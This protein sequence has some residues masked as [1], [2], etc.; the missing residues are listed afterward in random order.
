MPRR[1]LKIAGFTGRMPRLV[2]CGGRESAYDGFKAC[3]ARAS[4]REFAALLIDSE[5]P[6]R[7]VN[8]TWRHLR[9]GDH[10]VQP[11]GAQDNQVLLMTT[12]METWVMADPDAVERH[13]GQGLQKRELLP[14]AGLEKRSRAEVQDTLE[15]VT[16]RCSVPYQKG[17]KS[18]EVLGKLT[19][20]VLRKHL[21]SF[22]RA[23][24]ILEETL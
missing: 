14:V 13:F 10:W 11:R 6:I 17:P 19:P 9:R 20:K 1:L 5:E 7:D 22:R 2:A 18:Y 3:H 16:Q 24:Q 23:L 15:R 8:E 4:R 12:C 21:P